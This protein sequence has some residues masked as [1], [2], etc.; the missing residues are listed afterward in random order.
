[1]I[2]DFSGRPFDPFHGE[3]LASNGIIHTQMREIIENVN[4]ERKSRG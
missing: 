1:M 4:K 3:C 2:T